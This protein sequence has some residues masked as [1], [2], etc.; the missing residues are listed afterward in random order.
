MD[1]YSKSKGGFDMIKKGLICFLVICLCLV[2]MGGYKV[3]SAAQRKI[4]LSKKNL[5]M[6]KRQ[7]YKI[8]L[9]GAKSGKVKWSSSNK[10]IATV[11]KGKIKAK[12]KGKCTVI[13]KYNGKK[14]KCSVCIKDKE[15]ST[16]TPKSTEPPA[17]SLKPTESPAE[18]TNN[19][20]LSLHVK[21]FSQDTKNMVYTISNHS[22]ETLVLPTFFSLERY[23]QNAWESVT[24]T[25]S[26]V[27]AVAMLIAPHSTL[28][29]EYGL[30]DYFTD[31]SSGRYRL[32]V[33]TSYGKIC[34]E[35]F[36]IE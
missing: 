33:Q 12:K 11:K 10:K 19:D 26:S 32:S 4:G 20:K 7:T 13:A 16:A 30:N 36:A 22:E 28:E 15:Q 31:L 17:E 14:Y 27:K 34:S 18:N 35:E 9:K 23:H 6:K 29:F 8:K 21:S 3:S 5:T 25:D 24:R 2:N 1:M